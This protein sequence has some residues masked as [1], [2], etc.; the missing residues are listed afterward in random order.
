MHYFLSKSIK[1]DLAVPWK[2]AVFR[3]KENTLLCL[4][5]QVMVHCVK[6]VIMLPHFIGQS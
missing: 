3:A 4:S 1:S 2:L 5:L 6:R